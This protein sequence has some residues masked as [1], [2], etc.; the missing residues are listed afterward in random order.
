M[1]ISDQTGVRFR[2]GTDQDA[3]AVAALFRETRLSAMPYLPV[4]HTAREDEE[5]FLDRVFKTGNVWIAEVGGRIAGFTAFREGW[6]GIGKN[7]LNK[8][9]QSYPRLSLVFQRNEN[10]GAFYSAMGFACVKQT[11]GSDNEER[12]PDALFSW[13]PTAA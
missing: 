11:D 4:L 7:L 5:Y 10:A 3:R 2:R 12:E 9:K 6:V 8:A 13:D 1:S